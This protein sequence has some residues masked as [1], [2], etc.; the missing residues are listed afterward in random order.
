MSLKT[1]GESK[2]RKLPWYG[3]EFSKAAGFF[4]A[5]F[6]ITIWSGFLE[7]VL[8]FEWYWYL[9]ITI[10]FGIPLMKSMFID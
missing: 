10:L 2:V 5:L 4:F 1:W 7:F 6:L 9:I 3:F 8:R